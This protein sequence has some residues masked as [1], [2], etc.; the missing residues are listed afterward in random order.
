MQI[1]RGRW[2]AKTLQI[3]DWSVRTTSV[4][5]GAF[6]KTD[7]TQLN[8]SLAP[9]VRSV[10]QS[11]IA[12]LILVSAPIII[13][14]RHKVDRTARMD[15]VRGLLDQ[16]CEHT[17][18]GDDFDHE[19]HRRVTLFQHKFFYWRWPFFG[20]WLIPVE[21]SGHKTRKTDAIFRAPDDGEQCEG[22]AGRAWSSNRTVYVPGL[23]QLKGIKPSDS[24][25]TT[26]ASKSFCSSKR[27]RSK[28]PQARSLYGIPVEVGN[29]RWGVLV[30]D[31]VREGFQ[32]RR[33]DQIFSYLAPT[34]SN[35]LK[36]A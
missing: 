6:A 19:Q 23:P 24:D 30:V 28:P 22:V 1:G 34:L 4:I 16:M 11:W 27:L 17:F 35:N 18:R 31:S 26:Y 29:K 20:G 7:T 9:L 25:F 12:P 14:V 32:T 5:V 13:T 33:F 21:R 10:Q 36:G 15:A 8:A 3:A 2:L